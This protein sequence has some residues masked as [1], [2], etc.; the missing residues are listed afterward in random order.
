MQRKVVNYSV[1]TAGVFIWAVCSA[2]GANVDWPVYLGDKSSSHF[3]ELKQINRENVARLET[4]W[5]FHSGDG[6]KDNRSQIQ[7]NPLIIEG[8]LYGTSPLL[9]LLALDAATG[10][11]RWRFDPFAT[12]PAGSSLGVNRGVVFWQ[13]EKE[14]RILF[15][16]GQRLYAIHAE[17]GK[18][19]T[20]FGEQGSVDLRAGLG[21]D[22]EK[23]FVLANTPGVIYRDLLI[24]GTRVSE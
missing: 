22:P 24:L 21:R 8:V 1:K 10:R 6:R 14:Q 20:T 2:L 18:P 13:K 4:A 16:A 9:K 7:C 15:T 3:S 19:V 17:N 23:Q 5:E 11:E 12:N